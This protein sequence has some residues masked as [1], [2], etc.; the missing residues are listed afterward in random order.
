MDSYIMLY[1][2]RDILSSEL[3]LFICHDDS[4]IEPTVSVGSIARR[5]R[6]ARKESLQSVSK[7][8]GITSAR[9]SRIE[10]LRSSPHEQEIRAVAR[11]FGLPVGA[12]FG[13]QPSSLRRHFQ[14]D[15][16]ADTRLPDL[17]IKRDRGDHHPIVRAAL[18]LK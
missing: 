13:E 1:T 18:N 10:H 14:S 12:L 5:L 17:A 8:A 16:A 7:R 11:A 4:E 2:M 3:G 6:E 15:L 9:L